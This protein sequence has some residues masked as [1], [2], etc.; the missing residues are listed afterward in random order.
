[1]VSISAAA[2]RHVSHPSHSPSELPG[3]SSMAKSRVRLQGALWHMQYL[4]H[5]LG[6]WYYVLILLYKGLLLGGLPDGGFSGLAV[7]TVFMSET[8]A[9][10]TEISPC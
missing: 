1:M 2:M 7:L 3:I 9:S 5:Q 10:W 8:G 4:S 6:Y